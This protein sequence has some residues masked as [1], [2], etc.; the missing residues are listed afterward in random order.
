M[1]KAYWLMTIFCV[2]VYLHIIQFY[3]LARMQKRLQV[4]E[5]IIE[6]YK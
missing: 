5:N 2:Y 3:L 4:L 6:E 1:F